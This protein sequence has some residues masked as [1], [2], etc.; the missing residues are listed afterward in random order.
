M[1]S[2]CTYS[3]DAVEPPRRWLRRR[4]ATTS[5]TKCTHQNHRQPP[6]RR[7]GHP[8]KKVART[9][10][11]ACSRPPTL[12]HS[13]HSNS[14]PFFTSY[15]QG[16]IESPPAHFASAADM[17]YCVDAV[18]RMPLK[19]A[20]RALKGPPQPVS[21]KFRARHFRGEHVS[22]ETMSEGCGESLT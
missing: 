2:K 13:D 7:G 16:V 9:S 11:T 18:L 12:H 1:R 14:L 3:S 10:R 19:K 22:F 21:L 5:T 15:S 6:R 20:S 17:H 8:E 4:F